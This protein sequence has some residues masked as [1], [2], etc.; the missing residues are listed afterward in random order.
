[1]DKK[2]DKCVCREA[3][4]Q[5]DTPAGTGSLL[6][7]MGSRAELRSPGLAHALLPMGPSCAFQTEAVSK[8]VFPSGK[9]FSKLSEP[10][11]M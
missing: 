10:R 4:R 3:E 7:P 1:M 2:M 5:T 9:E 11:G 6:P 8:A